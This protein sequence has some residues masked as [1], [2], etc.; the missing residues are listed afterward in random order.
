[1]ERGIEATT[2]VRATFDRATKA[3]RSH[4]IAVLTSRP[5]TPE[6]RKTMRFRSSIA[7]SI[8]DDFTVNHEVDVTLGRP[9][10]GSTMTLPVAW[11]PASHVSVLPSFIG[12]LQAVD[13]SAGTTLRLHGRYTVPLGFVG[14]FGD[15][16][17]GRRLARQSVNELLAR[18]ARNLDRTV[19][20]RT[21]SAVHRPAPYNVDLREHGRVD[22][23]T[24]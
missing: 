17:L 14:R 21:R 6:E 7:A 8:G 11:K 5:A 24:R 16:V 19:D 22:D 23:R 15:S 18:I 20:D 3:L 4:P 13:T 10:T 1:M 2:S 12:E 9:S